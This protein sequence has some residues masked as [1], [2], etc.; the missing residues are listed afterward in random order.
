MTTYPTN[1]EAVARY[2]STQYL[3]NKPA[4]QHNGKKGYINKGD[5]P[6]SKDKDSNTGDTVG[7]HVRDGAPTE[8]STAPSGGA[9][10]GA[11]VLETNVQSSRPSRTV[12]EIL[13]AHPMND[14]DFLGNTNSSDVSV[15]TTNSK[16]MMAGSNITELHTHRYKEPVPPELLNKVP[17]V[18]QVCDLAQKYQLDP[19][20]K[21]KDSNM[22]LKTNNVTHAKDIDLS[23]QENQDYYNRHDQQIITRKHDSG[24]RYYNQSDQQFIV[25][26]QDGGLERVTIELVP[27]II[28]EEEDTVYQ[29]ADKYDQWDNSP[30]TP[31]NGNEVGG[32]RTFNVDNS[33]FN[34]TKTKHNGKLKTRIVSEV[35]ASHNKPDFYIGKRQS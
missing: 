9:S 25:C 26:K 27:D 10:I 1:I 19:S 31:T 15:D 28:L 7:T 4:N 16:E 6:K 8:E 14:D 35:S 13:G 5:D 21:S 17:N 33:V 11:Q 24:Q 23:S 18:P 32:S 34:L 12:E 30:Y 2:L 20:D 22:L 29:W 3:N